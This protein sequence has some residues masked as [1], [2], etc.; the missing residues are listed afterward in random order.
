MSYKKS[1]KNDS[2]LPTETPKRRGRPKGSTDKT[3]RKKRTDKQTFSDQEITSGTN[4]KTT[5]FA[6]ELNLLPDININDPSEVK[7]RISDYFKLCALYDFKPSVSTLAM[8]FSVSRIT[9]FNWL[10]DRTGTIKNRESFN[11][12]KKAYD[13]INGLYELYLNCG[14]INPV[15]AFFLM[16]NN[17]GYKDTTDYV[18]TNGSDQT[19]T[20]SD[21]ASRANLL[22]D[23]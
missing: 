22:T 1:S 11:Q 12:L 16:K 6:L 14:S 21:I 9:L 13:T 3:E 4:S 8:A 2:D 23:E 15:S 7:Q 19:M 20:L 5:S 10:N 18:V 17:Y